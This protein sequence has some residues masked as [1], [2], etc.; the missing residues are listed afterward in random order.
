MAE[1]IRKVSNADIKYIR[2]IFWS[3]TTRMDTPRSVLDVPAE[4]SDGAWSDDGSVV[5]SVAAANETAEEI[6]GDTGRAQP[7]GRSNLSKDSAPSTI[8]PIKDFDDGACDDFEEDG[9][10]IEVFFDDNA[11]DDFAVDGIE[12]FDDGGRD[13]FALNVATGLGVPR[14]GTRVAGAGAR[15]GSWDVVPWGSGEASAAAAAAAVELRFQ[16]RRMIGDDF[17]A[18]LC[19]G[20]SSVLGVLTRKKESPSP[21]APD[22]ASTAGSTYADMTKSPPRHLWCVPRHNHI[23]FSPRRPGVEAYSGR[24][25]RGTVTRLFGA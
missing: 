6:V 19:T 3:H 10:G 23:F 13:D 20:V 24:T 9:D 2:T 17:H 8:V 22:G 16:L 14:D 15:A 4:V 7:E 12:E 5:E 1:Y 18:E 21:P 11:H 25:L